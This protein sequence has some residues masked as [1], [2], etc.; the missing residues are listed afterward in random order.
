MNSLNISVV[1]N[2]QPDP[3][4]KVKIWGRG[5]LYTGYAVEVLQHLIFFSHSCLFY[6]N[7]PK[8]IT[9]LMEHVQ[10][11][12]TLFLVTKIRQSDV[13]YAQTVPQVTN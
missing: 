6:R 8:L 12:H 1:A 10:L 13:S 5:W 4:P 3:L 9:I 7:C 11:H 2:V